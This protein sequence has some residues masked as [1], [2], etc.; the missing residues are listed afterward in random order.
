MT[1]IDLLLLLLIAG[2]CGAVAQGLVGFSGGGCLFSI[3]VGFIG[4]V[5][6]TWLARAL[7]LP[8][9]FVVEV[10]TTTFPVVWSLIGAVLFVGVVSLLRRRPRY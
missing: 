1:L 6:G 7:D 3:G 2:I 5:L 10:S 8:P 4:A 9:I